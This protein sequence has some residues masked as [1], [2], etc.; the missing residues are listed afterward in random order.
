MDIDRYGRIVG[1]VTCRGKDA[2]LVQLQTGHAWVYDTYAAKYKVDIDN[3]RQ[4]EAEAK[5]AHKG[6]WADEDSKPPW[7]WRK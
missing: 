6:L 7:E 1:F 3:Y 5:A 2:G 4:T